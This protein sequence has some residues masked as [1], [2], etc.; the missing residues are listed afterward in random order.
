MGQPSSKDPPPPQID[1]HKENNTDIFLSI[2]LHDRKHVQ[3]R[4][5]LID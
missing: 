4:G 3:T 2:F 1:N 5:I